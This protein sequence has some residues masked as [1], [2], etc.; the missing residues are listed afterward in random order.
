MDYITENNKIIIKK[1]CIRASTFSFVMHLIKPN[2]EYFEL[3][4]HIKCPVYFPAI[5]TKT[6]V[7]RHDYMFPKIDEWLMFQMRCALN[8]E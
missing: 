5:I 6:A 8:N 3:D 1:K 2:E 7:L 4:A